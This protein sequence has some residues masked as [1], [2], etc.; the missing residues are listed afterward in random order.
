M[1]KPF[2][3]HKI[4]RYPLVTEKSQSQIDKRPNHE[5]YVFVV[6]KSANKES[7]R[8]AI[9]KLYRVN[10]IKVNVLRTS[11]SRGKFRNEAFIHPQQKRAIVTLAAG[12]KNRFGK[13]NWL[14]CYL[15]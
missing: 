12:E 10:A 13:E 15:G 8:Q 1:S 5:K 4:L 14:T 3:Y 11:R 2:D 9:Y 6:D 7:I